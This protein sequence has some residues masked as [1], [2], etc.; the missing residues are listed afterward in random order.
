ME[1]QELVEQAQRLNSYVVA[2][3]KSRNPEEFFVLS[4]TDT[5]EEGY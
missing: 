3:V 4:L 1:L 2:I 5:Y